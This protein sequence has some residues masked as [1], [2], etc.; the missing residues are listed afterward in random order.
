MQIEGQFKTRE[1]LKEHWSCNFASVSESFCLASL[2]GVW[3]AQSLVVKFFFT[4]FE[5]RV[6]LLEVISLK[7]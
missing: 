5:F 4:I 6:H 1:A 2:S 7:R 3:S